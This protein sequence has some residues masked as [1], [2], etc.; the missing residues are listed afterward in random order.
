MGNTNRE[1]IHNAEP[2]NAEA[3]ATLTSSTRLA[4]RSRTTTRWGAWRSMDGDFPVDASGTLRF[5]LQENQWQNAD[6]LITTIAD[7]RQA[8]A[9]YVTNWFEYLHGR[10]PGDGD[11]PLIARLAQVSVSGD[12]NIKDI[13]VGLVT[14]E[15]FL[16]RAKGEAQ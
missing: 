12:A 4:S 6:E 7:S 2:R 11:A 13:L 8:H 9:C 5:D 16:V 10:L 3:L 15:L 1:R 14:S